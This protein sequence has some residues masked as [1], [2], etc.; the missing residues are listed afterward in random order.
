VDKIS[1]AKMPPVENFNPN[2]RRSAKQAARERD[3]S[4]LRAGRVSRADMSA[5]NG[6]FS[7]LDLA[8]AVI[9]RRR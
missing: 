2:D 5:L 4:D 6:A 1:D 3:D 8:S 7:S 9:R